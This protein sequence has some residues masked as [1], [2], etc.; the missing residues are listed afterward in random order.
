MDEYE[1]A[2][3]A[4]EDA[5]AKLDDANKAVTTAQDN[6]DQAKAAEASAQQEKQNTEAALTTAQAKKQETANALAAATTACGNAQDKLNDAQKALD[7]AIS[8]TGIDLKALEIGR[9][10]V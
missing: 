7:A 9:A 1:A 10:H 8:G 4:V 5:R 6:L 3:K 2:K